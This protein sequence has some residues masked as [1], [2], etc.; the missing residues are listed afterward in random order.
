MAKKNEAGMTLN[1]GY[2]KIFMC[3]T[4]NNDVEMTG[5]A[6]VQHLKK[7]HNVDTSQKASRTLNLH[8]N[9]RPRHVSVYQWDFKEGVVLIETNY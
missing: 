8:I 6:A 9:K 4:C 3:Q 1:T 7:H 2:T 5:K